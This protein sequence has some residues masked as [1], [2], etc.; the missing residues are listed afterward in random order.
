MEKIEKKKVKEEIQKLYLEAVDS[1]IL[2]RKAFWRDCEK[3][4]GCKT[5]DE[6]E[7][8]EK[9]ETAKATINHQFWMDAEAEIRILE[10]VLD[11]I[12]SIY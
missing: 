2:W 8:A 9:K 11:R 12:S 6:L 4:F 1:K 3:D 5:W 10:K 7:K